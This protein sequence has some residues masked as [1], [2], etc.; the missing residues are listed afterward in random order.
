M[1]NAQIGVISA[2]E[3]N[4]EPA[5]LTDVECRLEEGE[6]LTEMTAYISRHGCLLV[7]GSE[8]ALAAVRATGRAFPALTEPEVL[9]RVRALPPR[10]RT[11][12][13]SSS[14]TSSTRGWRERDRPTSS[15]G[16]RPRSSRQGSDSCFSDNS[17]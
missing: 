9:E 4:Y 12:S 17:R 15:A 7:D 6:E 2:T 13:P 8:V 16:P 14:P 1:T 3:P 11:S 10:T 5:T